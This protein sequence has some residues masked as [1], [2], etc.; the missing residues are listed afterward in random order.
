MVPRFR[1][2]HNLTIAGIIFL[3]RGLMRNLIGRYMHRGREKAVANTPHFTIIFTVFYFIQKN[4]DTRRKTLH[5]LL[6]LPPPTRPSPT[7]PLPKTLTHP[8]FDPHPPTLCPRPS[9]THPLPKVLLLVLY[10][11]CL[12]HYLHT[13]TESLNPGAS[14]YCG[15]K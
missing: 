5:L 2:K 4:V 14:G 3:Y 1:I 6:L 10:F 8:P 12:Q 15:I 11:I 7:H 13:R 9:P